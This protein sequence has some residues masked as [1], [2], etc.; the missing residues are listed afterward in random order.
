M[1]KVVKVWFRL[2][3]RLSFMLGF[4]TIDQLYDNYV[5]CLQLRLWIIH[6]YFWIEFID[7]TGAVSYKNKSSIGCSGKI[8]M[9]ADSRDGRARGQV[10][11]NISLDW[12]LA[13][14]P[15]SY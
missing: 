7:F 2:W 10:C 3:L 6:R 11:E 14:S 13:S 1:V 9:H 12:Q 4:G 8:Q 15:S 5:I